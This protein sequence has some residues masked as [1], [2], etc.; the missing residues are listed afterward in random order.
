MSK[1]GLAE[2]GFTKTG[3]F[4]LL[5]FD[6][7]LFPF[8]KFLYTG[9]G[10]TLLNYNFPCS[11]ILISINIQIL[12][13]VRFGDICDKH[14]CSRTNFPQFSRLYSVK[15]VRLFIRLICNKL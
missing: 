15:T 14:C 11:F 12:K 3:N 5:V 1:G 9:K 4:N 7:V 2:S 13:C 8:I 6:N 10:Y